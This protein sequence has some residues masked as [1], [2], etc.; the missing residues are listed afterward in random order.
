M[1][2]AAEDAFVVGRKFLDGMAAYVE[3][4]PGKVT[5]LV[6]SGTPARGMDDVTVRPGELGFELVVDGDLREMVSRHA[7]V[8]GAAGR[9]QAH[10]AALC[11]KA[12]VPCVYVTEYTLLTRLQIVFAGTRNPL[13]RA[14]RSFWEWR[15]ERMMRR[16]LRRSAGAQCNGTPT[17]RSYKHIVPSPLLFFDTRSSSADMA[18]DAELEARL[19]QLMGNAPLRLAFSGRL[20]PMKGADHLIDVARALSA[21]GVA[22]TMAICGDG[23]LASS[24]RER[25]GSL[26]VEMR[27]VLDFKT[28]LQPFL[29][30][31]C[32]LFVCCH[33]QGD[34]SC[35]YLETMAAGVPIV[36]YANE[37]FVGVNEASGSAGWEVPMNRPELMAQRI[38]SLTRQEI[39]LAS[40]KALAFARKHSCESVFDQRIE[41]LV[42]IASANVRRSV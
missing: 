22:Y 30:S 19:A 3:R 4:W 20:A 5:V 31:S 29:K 38:A 24:M 25:I 16:A 6:R 18:Q 36:G 17:F 32:D 10:V 42:Q 21:R 28:E 9:E 39:A 41:H 11:K 23:E 33:R 14:R 34:P 1:S 40:R 7:V 8:L 13:L 35:T 2:P 26:P 15:T 37:A 12:S 27:G